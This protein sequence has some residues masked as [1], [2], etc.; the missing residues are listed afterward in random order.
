MLCGLA[1]VVS[2]LG[3]SAQGLSRVGM[4]LGY[5][6]SRFTGADL[7]G[8][9]V[10]SQSGLALGGYVTYEFTE[11]F[12]L[13]QEVLFTLKGS[14]VNT[15][16]NVWLSNIFLYVEMPLLGK[17]TFF[18]ENRLRPNVYAG[19]AVAALIGAFNNTGLLEDIRS[20][21]LGFVVGGGVEIWKLSLDLRLTRGLLNFDQSARGIDLKHQTIS[22]MMG[23]AF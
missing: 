7:P 1:L 22:V 10:D 12:S 13:Q 8:K 19:P 20:Y 17:A 18:P 2:T 14:K 16:G 9:G 3:V 23:Y 5:N 15:I 4:K 21:D 11:T 6:S